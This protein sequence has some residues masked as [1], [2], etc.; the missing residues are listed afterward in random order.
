[1]SLTTR[2]LRLAKGRIRYYCL[3]NRKHDD[4]RPATHVATVSTF[5]MTGRGHK[6]IRRTG[7]C[8]QCALDYAEKHKLKLPT[9][10]TK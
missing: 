7:L 1:M 2:T 3:K 4:S 5:V 9:P 10:E 8:L 6:R